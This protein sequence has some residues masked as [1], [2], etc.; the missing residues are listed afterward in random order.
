MLVKGAHVFKCDGVH[1][2]VKLLY[3]SFHREA[4]VTKG[5]DIYAIYDHYDTDYIRGEIHSVPFLCFMDTMISLANII[6]TP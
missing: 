2:N 4:V 3:F 6:K 5:I 1:R